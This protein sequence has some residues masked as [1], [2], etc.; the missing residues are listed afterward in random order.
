MSYF[1]R[2]AVWDKVAIRAVAGYD[3]IRREVESFVARMTSF[4]AEILNLA[5]GTASC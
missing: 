2:D 1:A 4:D 3:D 5:V